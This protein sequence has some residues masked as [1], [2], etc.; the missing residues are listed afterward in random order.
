M[1]NSQ[2]HSRRTLLNVNMFELESE[3]FF[4]FIVVV[5]T[6][7]NRRMRKPERSGSC[8]INLCWMRYY[9]RHDGICVS[10]SFQPYTLNA[11]AQ[12]LLTYI[13]LM[14]IFFARIL[15]SVCARLR[16]WNCKLQCDLQNLL[17][18]IQSIR[19][20]LFTLQAKIHLLIFRGLDS[21]KL[22]SVGN[23]YF[24]KNFVGCYVVE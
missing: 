5:V 1:Q 16:I 21:N 6:W 23:F 14:A 9:L 22:G 3:H 7:E 12:P 8:N 4:F 24:L 10:P 11:H 18:S 17:A 20:L 15:V 13:F 19:C 2:N